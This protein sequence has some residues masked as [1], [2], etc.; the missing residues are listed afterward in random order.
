MYYDPNNPQMLRTED[1]VRLT[2]SEIQAA[3]DQI[4]QNMVVLLQKI[5]ENFARCNQV[6]VE[7]I[8]PAVTQHGENSQRIYESVKVRL[9]QR[10]GATASKLTVVR[11][12]VLEALFRGCCSTTVL[13]PGH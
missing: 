2:P 8:L 7:R 10:K 5:E 11:S 6:V 13:R 12:T 3:S 1:I 9:S 4:D